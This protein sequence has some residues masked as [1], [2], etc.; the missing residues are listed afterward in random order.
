MSLV[1]N[2]LAIG[3]VQ[4]LSS[5]GATQSIV[6]IKNYTVFQNDTP[7]IFYCNGSGYENGALIAWI[8]NRTGYGAKHAQRGITYVIDPPIGDTVSSRLFI[9]SYSTINNRTEVYCKT[10][11]TISNI[12]LIS[13]PAYL[14]IQGLLDAPSNFSVNISN[15][16]NTTFLLSWG[17]P[18]SLDVTDSP[19]IFYYTLCANITIY[20]CKNISSDPDCTFP[21]TCTSSVDF[22]IPSLNGTNGGQNKTIMDYGDPIYFTFFAVNGAGNGSKANLTYCI[23]KQS[24]YYLCFP[25][26]QLGHQRI[27]VMM[28]AI[29]IPI[30][31]MASLAPQSAATINY[32]IVYGSVCGA[33]VLVISAV[34]CVVCV[35][36]CIKHKHKDHLENIQMEENH[37]YQMVNKR[38]APDFKNMEPCCAYGVVL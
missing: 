23:R 38:T 7:A 19:D 34:V 33:S 25:L 18:F 8:L 22:T 20:G 6:L 14:T 31:P 29:N 37:A 32:A 27:D 9:P 2:L 11:D 28:T 1:L 12:V 13:E 5:L 16:S 15:T 3:H 10:L 24:G 30:T 17:A 36:V 4:H 21:R 35:I 26:F